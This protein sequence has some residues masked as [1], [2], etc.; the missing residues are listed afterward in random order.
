MNTGTLYRTALLV[1]GVYTVHPVAL[2]VVSRTGLSNR[3][4]TAGLGHE[5]G[6]EGEGTREGTGSRGVCLLVA[7]VVFRGAWECEWVIGEG[8]RQGG[9]E[10]GR[11]GAAG[12]GGGAQKRQGR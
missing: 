2:E 7:V 6:R 9:R 11:E 4:A 12:V 10:A 8:G 1:Y 3:S 5:T